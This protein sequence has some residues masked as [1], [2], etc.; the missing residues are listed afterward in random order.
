LQENF[1]D[2]NLFQIKLACAGLV[3]LRFG[4]VLTR[5]GGVRVV[6]WPNLCWVWFS[7]G[8]E[9]C[10]VQSLA[11]INFSFVFWLRVFGLV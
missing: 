9:K 7:L 10:V 4:G 1:L 11:P 3:L 8:R 6:R 5:F 2:G